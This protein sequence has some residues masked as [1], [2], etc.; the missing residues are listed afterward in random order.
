MGINGQPKNYFKQLIL[1]CLFKFF[2]VADFYTVGLFR[3]DLPLKKCGEFPK[4]FQ[5]TVLL[6]TINST[7]L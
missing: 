7:S 2:Q 4:S 1:N 3:V 5:K 6:I